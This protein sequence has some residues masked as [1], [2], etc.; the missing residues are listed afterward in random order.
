MTFKPDVP[1]AY[2]YLFVFAG[3]LGWFG[4]SASAPPPLNFDLDATNGKFSAERKNRESRFNFFTVAVSFCP[5]ILREVLKTIVCPPN[6]RKQSGARFSL[7]F[8]GRRRR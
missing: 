3:Y 6:N 2:R 5:G 8:H 7:S 4:L 1:A